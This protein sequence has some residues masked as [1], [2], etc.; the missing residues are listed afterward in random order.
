MLGVA[1]DE[2][3]VPDPERIVDGFEKEFKSLRAAAHV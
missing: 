1:T 3:L 2:G